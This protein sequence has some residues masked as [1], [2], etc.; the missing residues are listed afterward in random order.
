MS[1]GCQR[2]SVSDHRVGAA[3]RA[4]RVRRALRQL[5]VARLARASDVTVSRIERGRLEEVSIATLR[6]VGSA[7]DL[8]VDPVARWRG[9]E[10]ER[11]LNAR[12]SALHEAAAQLFAGHREWVVIPEA[13]FSHFG[14]RGIV[15]V[16]GWHPAERALVI[17][18]L[19]SELVDIQEVIGTLD[20]KRRLGRRFANDRGWD[21]STISAW[22]ILAESRTNR[23]H[24]ASHRTV[25][26]T[27]FPSDGHAM[28]SW[29]LM[30]NR[31]I[32]AMSFLPFR[33]D[34]TLRRGLTAPHRVRGP[35]HAS[36][37]SRPTAMFDT[38]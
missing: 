4:I 29:L 9:G 32:A 20:R 11:L 24:V 34:A 8:R 14:E 10:L 6:R 33:Q 1:D 16:L 31:P 7:L 35:A 18:E 21:P 28:R 27:A 37:Q 12:H 19:K 38:D 2:A 17:V 3:F 22:L 30:P 26:R 5:D 13:S 15:D 23:R 36:R 25:L